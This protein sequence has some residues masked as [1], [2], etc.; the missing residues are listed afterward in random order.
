MIKITRIAFLILLVG[1][2]CFSLVSY[3]VSSH[4]RQPRILLYHH[5][6][7]KKIQGLRLGFAKRPLNSDTA[8]EELVQ[9]ML[10]RPPVVFFRPLFSGNAE[11]DRVQVVDRKVYVNLNLENG[12]IIDTS[13][14]ALLKRVIRVNFPIFKEVELLINGSNNL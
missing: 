10:H 7:E 3:F 12:T 14:V 4:R 1:V 13:D 11:L 5:L 2:F 8:V 9:V 6:V